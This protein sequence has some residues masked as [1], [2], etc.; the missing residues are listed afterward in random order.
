MP[1]RLVL[2]TPSVY[3][4]VF[5][6][7]LWYALDVPLETFSASRDSARAETVWGANAHE[8]GDQ[9]HTKSSKDTPGA[10]M[11]AGRDGRQAEGLVSVWRK[12]G[13]SGSYRVF[14]R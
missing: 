12:A 7:V 10:L 4:P 8:W 9:H 5:S 6:A 2:S 3:H 11:T 1:I 14:G 13:K